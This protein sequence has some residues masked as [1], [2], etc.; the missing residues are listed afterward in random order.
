[1]VFK[2]ESSLRSQ[3]TRNRKLHPNAILLLPTILLLRY[4]VILK[5]CSYSEI[6]NR[7]DKKRVYKQSLSSH[8]Y[9]TN[10]TVAHIPQRCFITRATNGATVHQTIIY[11]SVWWI[12]IE[13]PS[14]VARYHVCK[15]ERRVCFVPSSAVL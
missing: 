8:Y 5:Y 1:M 2:F 3:N 10:T 13:L 12:F 9:N 15:R 6:K 14:Q 11:N 4:M 7:R